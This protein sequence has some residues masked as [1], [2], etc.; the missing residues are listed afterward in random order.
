MLRIHKVV[1]ERAHESKRDPEMNVKHHVKLFV[2]H[3]G[4]GTRGRVKTK[5]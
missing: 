5:R 3:L 1:A 4:D 2:G